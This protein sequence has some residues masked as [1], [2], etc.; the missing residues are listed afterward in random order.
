MDSVLLATKER[1]SV[2]TGPR[3][4]KG[5]KQFLP[6]ASQCDRTIGPASPPSMPSIGPPSPPPNFHMVSRVWGAAL[7]C[8]IAFDLQYLVKGC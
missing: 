3:E 7:R 2:S 1:A 6:Q 8:T 4:Q 5:V